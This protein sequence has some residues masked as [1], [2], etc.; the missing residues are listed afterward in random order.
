MAV[1]CWVFWLPHSLWLQTGL[2]LTPAAGRLCASIHFL[3]GGWVFGWVFFGR[4]LFF[5]FPVFCFFFFLV[6][7]SNTLQQRNW[8]SCLKVGHS[9]AVSIE[10]SSQR[11]VRLTG[12]G[13][14]PRRPYSRLSPLTLVLRSTLWGHRGHTVLPGPVLQ[15]HSSALCAPH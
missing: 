9:S 3:K 7:R 13:G 2:S 10:T 12:T 14:A 8:K 6:L 1:Q 4:L 15:P 11:A 5:F